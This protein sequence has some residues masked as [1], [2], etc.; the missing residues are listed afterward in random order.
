MIKTLA[1]L[2]LFISSSSLAQA[3]GFPLAGLEPIPARFTTNRSS[4]VLAKFV[5]PLRNQ[6]YFGLCAA[7]SAASYI[8][9]IGC[10]HANNF[11][12]GSLPLNKMVSVLDILRL[13]KSE[14]ELAAIRKRPDFPEDPSEADFHRGIKFSAA[15]IEYIFRNSMSVLPESIAPFEPAFNG[16]DGKRTIEEG[17][18]FMKTLNNIYAQTQKIMNGKGANPEKAARAFVE[19]NFATIDSLFGY[20]NNDHDV[21]ES[22]LQDNIN[23]FYDRLFLPNIVTPDDPVEAREFRRQ[24]IHVNLAFNMY[25][26]ENYPEPISGSEMDETAAAK[27]IG[28]YKGAIATIKKN[29]ASGMPLILRHICLR[30][31]PPKNRDDCI[32][33][34]NEDKNQ[35]LHHALLVTGYKEVCN[36]ADECFDAI[37]VHNSWGAAWQKQFTHDGLD[38]WVKAKPMLDRTF[39]GQRTPYWFH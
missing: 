23:F 39:Y 7:F 33:A 11:D 3:E 28:D 8:D 37:R 15:T 26:F 34:R 27:N 36:A 32:D 20:P 22:F 29:L 24:Q 25:R 9:A 30:E 10:Y 38:G 35:G 5:P 16:R 12:C 2:T 18:T 6:H 1:T 4:L 13:D 21:R 14:D 31:T 19:K 17:L